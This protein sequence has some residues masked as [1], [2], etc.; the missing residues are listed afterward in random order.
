[1]KVNNATLSSILGSTVE[2]LEYEVTN[3]SYSRLVTVTDGDRKQVNR[4]ASVGITTLVVRMVFHNT[5]DESYRLASKL[6]SYLGEAYVQFDDSLIYRVTVAT[7]GSFE[8][9]TPSLFFYTLQLQVL[10]KMSDG[11]LISTTSA[12]PVLLENEG[13]YR[14]PIIIEVTPTTSIASFSVYGF[15]AHTASTPLVV[16]APTINKKIII[17]GENCQVLQEVVGGY[18]NKFA[19]TNLI[20]F[21]E[22][23]VGITQLTFSPSTLNVTIKYNP[24]FI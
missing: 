2:F 4:R 19:S 23:P 10:D 20:S 11:V 21:P 3:P 17:D 24:R 7:D 6:V 14:T 1:M 15:G 16:S 18:E 8:A 9:L 22:I 5:K 12:A 13:T